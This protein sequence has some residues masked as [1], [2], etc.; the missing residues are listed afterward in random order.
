MFMASERK[1]LVELALE[2]LEMEMKKGQIDEG[3]AALTR[4]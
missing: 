4:A 3:I 2:S 1:R